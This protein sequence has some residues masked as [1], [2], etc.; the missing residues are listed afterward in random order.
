MPTYTVRDPQS[1]KTVK[2]TGESP[3]TEAELTQIFGSLATAAPTPAVSTPTAPVQTPEQQAFD[4][5][6]PLR[7]EMAD[8]N[9]K[10]VERG[11]ALMPTIGGVI[12]GAMGGIPGAALGGAAGEAFAQLDK[13]STGDAAPASAGEAAK[14][15]GLQGAVQ[16]AAQGLGSGLAALAGKSSTWLMN[17][18]V[19]ATDRLSRE[20]PELSK[21]LIEHSITV[22]QGGLNKARRLLNAAKAEAN[23][24]LKAADAKGVTIPITAATNGLSKT[25]TE[26]MNS[27]DPVGGL[28]ALA[29]AERNIISGRA[30]ELTAAAA[31]ALKR[32]L[33][34]QSKQLYLAA[35]MGNGRPGLAVMAQ[36]KADM[37]AALN[38]AIEQATTAAGAAG[39]K[40]ANHAA[41]EFIGAMRGVTKGIRPGANLYQA[42][43]RPGAG[44]IMGGVAGSQEGLPG[45]IAGAAT[46]AALTSP[47]GMSS[48]AIALANPGVRAMAKHLPRGLAA[49][50]NE[51]A[52]RSGESPTPPPPARR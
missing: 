40:A 9:R 39:Y 4:P 31:D 27:A 15:I 10:K 24:A 11:R 41:Q 49:L 25:L 12:G 29:K 28:S 6:S 46:G 5:N 33:Q 17:R 7:Q 48:Q 3:P 44:A 23:G 18:A 43:V 42:M 34:A 8:Y 30:Q 20:F 14:G 2:L 22:S 45:A 50:F 1:G 51:F 52:A 38:E 26:V 32:S 21:T 37:A 36:A 19:N 35:K 16:G 13:R 47:L